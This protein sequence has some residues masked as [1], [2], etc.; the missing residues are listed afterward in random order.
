V[1]LGFEQ[2]HRLEERLLLAG[3]ELV[4][5]AGDRA[6]GAV[7][8]FIDQPGLVGGDRDDGA[9]PV[10]GVGVPF[11]EARAVEVGEDAADGGQGQ[12]KSSGQF[13]DRD[14]A[15]ANLLKRGNVPGAER[16]GHRGRGAV[17]PAPHPA[18]D[19][20]KQMHQP[21]AQHRVL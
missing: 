1:K 17:L 9:P 15:A 20:G 19:A 8:P 11:D 4:E 12:P 18:R 7:E 2:V 13:T 3:G 21:Q 10:G 14:R 16:R 6:G 5:D